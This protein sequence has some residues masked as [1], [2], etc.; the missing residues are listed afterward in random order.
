V[1]TVSREAAVDEGTIPQRLSASDSLM[2]RIE[3]DPVLRSPILVVGLLD[4]SPTP[5]GLEAAIDRAVAALPRL[6][7]RIVAPPLGLGRPRWEDAGEPSQAHHVRRVRA[8]GGDL[9]SVLEVAQPD[10]VAAFDPARPPWTLTVVDGLDGG[11]AAIVLRFHHAITDGIGGIELAQRLFDRKRRPTRSGRNGPGTEAGATSGTGT[12]ASAPV[13]AAPTPA[14]AVPPL[15]E[16]VTGAAGAVA[17]VSRDVLDLSRQALGAATR[18]PGDLVAAPL[19]LGRSAA[20]LLAPATGGGSPALA[21]RS[22]DRWLSTTERPL[23]RVRAA[24]HATGGTVNDVLLA[25]VAGG[26][27]AYHK[28][29]GQPVGAVRVTMPI[30]IRREGDPVGGNRFVPARFTLPIDDPDPRMRVKIAGAIVRRWRAEPAL[31]ATGLL[32]GGLNMLPGPVVTRLF[33]EMLRS[34]DV[35]VVDVPGLDRRAFLGGARIDRLWA[36]APPTGAALSITLLSHEGV[37]CLGLACD[38]LAVTDPELLAGCLGDALDELL[39]LGGPAARS[40]GRPARRGSA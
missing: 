35:D 17:Q 8:P 24:A 13:P 4:R 39:A 34:I 29:Q 22:L 25:A 20:R 27:Y 15:A 40:P 2:W 30:S 33:G 36:F 6:R 19:R 18:R 12:P 10:A 14:P 32:A 31:G 3:S 5:E 9:D 16:L 23:E 21:G 7:Q 38:R 11:R 28:A 1:I 26:L 37:C